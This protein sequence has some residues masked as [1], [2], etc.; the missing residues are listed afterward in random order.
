[1]FGL[2]EQRARLCAAVL[3]VLG[4][5]SVLARPALAV[6]DRMLVTLIANGQVEEARALFASQGPTETDW[7]FF[8]GRVAKADGDFDRAIQVFRDVL[9][10][11]PSYLA[12]RRELAHSLLLVGDYRAS[13]HH[14]RTLLRIDPS[15]ELRRGYVTFLDEID[16]LRPFSLSGRFAIISSTNINRGSSQ[17]RFQPGVPNAPSFD[18]T[19]QAE[20]GTGVELG[21]AGRHL[22][23][24]DN[25][26]R[27]T[28]DW[29]LSTRQFSDSSHNS[30]SA[31]TRLQYARLSAQS[32]WSVGPFAHRL[33]TENEQDDRLDLGV[34]F[35]TDRRLNA[36]NTLFLSVSGEQRDNLSGDA[37][38]GPLYWMQFGLAR[39]VQ[40][41]VL[42]VGTRLIAHRP[43]RAH[44][45]YD[46]QSVFAHISRAW[47]GGLQGGIGIELGQRSYAALF[48]LAGVAR[49]DDYAQI[50]ISAHHEAIRFGRFMPTLRCTF[51][52]TSS[53][54]AFYDHDIEECTIGVT[55][56]F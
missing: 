28:L 19:S 47:S 9:L 56:R 45:Q 3:I 53:N 50:N 39:S 37:N 38:D 7:L 12:A 55:T 23:R 35:S 44:L 32:R 49:A 15:E 20:P 36:R 10:R 29:D 21:L 1:M 31:S 14:F 30:F 17:E 41:G 34:S 5:L 40:D 16:R 54:V 33:W 48:P 13:A 18:I 2:M 51:G 27:W 46:G 8:E 6:S 24:R 4:A 52:R 43:E 42:T 22:W 11:D 25:G 26:F